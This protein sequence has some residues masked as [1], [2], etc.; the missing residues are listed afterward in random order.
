[1]STDHSASAINAIRGTGGRWARLLGVL[2][3]GVWASGSAA[4]VEL[5][6]PAYFYPAGSGLT[7]W[8]QLAASAL[9][10]PVTAIL[11]PNSGPGAAVD[12]AYVSVTTNL[13]NAGGKVIGYVHTS[14]GARPLA[15]V[16]QDILAYRDMYAV[17][18][19]FI[20]EMGNDGSSSSLNYYSAVHDYIKALNPAYR[21]VGNPGTTTREIYLSRPTADAVVV[22]EDNYRA[23]RRYSPDAWNAAYPSARLGHLVHTTSDLNAARNALNLAIQRNAGLFYATSDKLLP[24]PWD[25]LPS[26]WN[27]LVTEVCLRNGAAASACQ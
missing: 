9:R 21:V 16:T 17:D 26:Y 20:D 14:Y 3:G 19:F 12:P 15:A 24:N 8:N 2:L 1:M 10:A 27:G 13:R 5:L 7:Y 25:S 22:F 11:N 6:V 23:Y 18:G 4:A